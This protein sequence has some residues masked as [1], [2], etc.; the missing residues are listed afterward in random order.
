MGAAQLE[1]NVH[2]VMFPIGRAEEVPGC[3]PFDNGLLQDAA[4]F[5][6]GQIE[7][8][9]GV[10]PEGQRPHR[11]LA[12]L[13]IHLAEFG[14]KM[15]RRPCENHQF[16]LL[17]GAFNLADQRP[18]AGVQCVPL[19][20][21][22]GIGSSILC[23]AEQ[24]LVAITYGL[25]QHGFGDLKLIFRLPTL[26]LVDVQPPLPDILHDRPPGQRCADVVAQ[27]C[28]RAVI[29]CQKEKPVGTVARFGAV[30]AQIGGDGFN[31]ESRLLARIKKFGRQQHEAQPAVVRHVGV[32]GKHMHTVERGESADQLFQDFPY[33]GVHVA[34]VVKTFFAI[35]HFATQIGARVEPV[36]CRLLR[37]VAGTVQVVQTVGQP[38]ENVGIG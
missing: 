6:A 24:P 23:W 27:K 20:C 29:W 17:A 7:I 33:F 25:E 30:V 21:R 36:S 3:C 18:T 32:R 4:V 15:H 19:D 13:P 38:A 34:F 37:P 9:Q 26:D 22:L 5:Q 2:A 14:A 16:V 12:R 35:F 10:F 31:G 11:R 28:K 1:T 8:A